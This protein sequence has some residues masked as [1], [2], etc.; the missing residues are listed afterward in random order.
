MERV[1]EILK[2]VPIEVVKEVPVYV[3]TDVT[4]VE[5]HNRQKGQVLP[6]VCVSASLFLY[7]SLSLEQQGEGS[8]ARYGRHRL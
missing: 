8:E 2:E 3:R 7:L 5:Q 1:V 4:D 6:S